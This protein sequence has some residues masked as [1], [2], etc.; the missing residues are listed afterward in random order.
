[1]IGKKGLSPK[2]KKGLTPATLCVRRSFRTCKEEN[3]FFCF[4]RLSS[5][6]IST[7]VTTVVKLC[8]KECYTRL[9]CYIFISYYANRLSCYHNQQLF[10]QF[11]CE[12][13]ISVDLQAEITSTP[14]AIKNKLRTYVYKQTLLSTN[15]LH[16]YLSDN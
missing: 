7:V 11:L 10:W 15:L 16:F 14:R 4:V 13:F 9:G 8:N 3:N 6:S 2:W 1:M 5:R 12:P